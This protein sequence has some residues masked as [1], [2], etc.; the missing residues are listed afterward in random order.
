LKHHIGFCSDFTE[1]E[2]YPLDISGEGKNMPRTLQR[3]NIK[4]FY[5]KKY[6]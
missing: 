1:E 2:W 5:W 6:A 4:T 3:T